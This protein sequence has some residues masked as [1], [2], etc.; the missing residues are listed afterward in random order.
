[1]CDKYW[2][3]CAEITYCSSQR[4]S[5]NFGAPC[6]L[7]LPRSPSSILI[8]PPILLLLTEGV[9]ASCSCCYLFTSQCMLDHVTGQHMLVS[10]MFM[11]M[12]DIHMHTNTFKD[13][14]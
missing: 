12:T 9:F 3:F 10:V 5:K 7:C 8:C 2:R 11:H 1:M 6:V 14:Q 4:P 13:Q